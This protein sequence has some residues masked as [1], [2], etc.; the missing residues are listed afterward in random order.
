[1]KYLLLIYANPRNWEHPMFLAAPESLEL[2]EEERA[3]MLGQAEDLWREI[4]ESGE[5]IG[6]GALADP[7]TTRTSTV[8]D[9]LAATT[10][11]PYLESKEQLA[12]YF[13]LDCESRQRADEIASRFPDVR[14]GAVEVRPVMDDSVREA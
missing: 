7:A 6:A 10:D 13:L 11:G 4:A 5:L 9:G 8:R 14:F 1:M 2:P 12:G 3:A